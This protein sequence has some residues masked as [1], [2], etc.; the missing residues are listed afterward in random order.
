MFDTVWAAVLALNSTVAK[1]YSLTE[2]DY[3]NDIGNV[4]LSTII[5]NEAK[6]VNFFGLTVS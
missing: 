1:G 6:N 3:T 2:F 4:S 5:F